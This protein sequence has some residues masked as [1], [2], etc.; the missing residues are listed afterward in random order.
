MEKYNLFNEHIDKASEQVWKSLKAYGVEQREALRI[1]L[2]FEE[3]LL[4]YQEKF[5]EKVNV[6]VRWEAWRHLEKS[7]VRP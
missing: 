1:K 2:M 3:I 7:G 6:C 4:E 5:G